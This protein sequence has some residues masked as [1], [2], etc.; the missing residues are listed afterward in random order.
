MLRQKTARMSCGFSRCICK[1]YS[2]FL[3]S[4]LSILSLIFFS[5]H[6]LPKNRGLPTTLE[7]CMTSPMPQKMV[8]R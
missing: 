4:S 1:R 7:A 8:T 6:S 3:L 5:S 2:F